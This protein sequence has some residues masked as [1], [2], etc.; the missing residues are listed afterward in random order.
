MAVT[1]QLCERI[2][3]TGYENLGSPAIEAARRLVLDGIAIAIAGTEEE[4]IHILAAHHKEQGGAAQ[5]TA[6]G[7]GF[8][9]NTVSAAALN[10]A[11]MHVLDFE[12]MWSPANHALSTTLAGVLALAE[13]RGATGREVLTAL[14][15]GVEM[16]GWIRQASGQYEA[17][18]SRFHPP[19]AAGPLGAA[20]AA[21]HL[22]KLDPGQLANAIGIAA[23]RAGSLLANAGTMTKSTHCGHAAALGLESALL[24]ARGFTANVEVFEAAQGYV[25]ALY[26]NDFKVDEML[27]YGRATLRVVD[28]G[29][30]IKMFPCQFGTH[31]GIT[32]GLELHRQI[33]SAAA[34]R[35]VILT[36]P[37]MNYVDRPRPK[38]GL[39]G[40]FSLQYTAASALLDGKVGIRTFT[41]A[42]LAQDDMQDL[43]GKFELRL[44]PTIPGR[45]EDMHVLLRVELDGG[46]V[47]ETRCDGPRGK[48]GTPPIS[49]AEHLVKVHDCLAT[50]LAPAA[51]ERVIALACRIDDLDVGGVRQLMQLAGCFA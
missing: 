23:S 33:P 36:A 51:A 11:A 43:L 21:G 10:G 31:F 41:D 15:N 28:P 35:R 9:L 27:G 18:T 6:I 16:Q 12:P 20:V 46:R 19:G 49:E 24:A 5:A 30:A 34:I 42:R 8:R 25:P 44:D 1:A 2:A 26:D 4:A 13:A 45:F 37:V 40:K 32:A 29:Y 7:N 38:T 14:V 47:L 22:L 3:A 17:N 50:R 39:S 48:W